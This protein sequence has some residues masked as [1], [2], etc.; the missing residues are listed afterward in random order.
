MPIIILKC[1]DTCEWEFVAQF[2]YNLQ[3]TENMLRSIRFVATE[4]VFM[5]LLCQ[6]YIKFHL[7]LQLIWV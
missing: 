1:L 5:A 4:I 3:D 2:L 7:E 6:G